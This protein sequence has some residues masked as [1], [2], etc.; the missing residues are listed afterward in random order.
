MEQNNMHDRENMQDRMGGLYRQ[1]SR[2]PVAG[3]S[4]DIA[5]GN[6]LHGGIVENVS[7]R[8]FKMTQ[9]GEW[10]RGDEHCYR[11]ILS[12]NGKHFKLIAK[13]C[14]R[15]ESEQGLEIGFKII[16]VSWEW[17]EMILEFE[18]QGMDWAVGNA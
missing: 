14:W 4:G 1:A 13:P 9:V 17:A 7:I 8:G 10:F 18:H 5:D 11:T 12:G 16:D 3:F 15:R 2:T 6:R